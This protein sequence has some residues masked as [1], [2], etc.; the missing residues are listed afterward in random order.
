MEL[1]PNGNVTH[2]HSVV[3]PLDYRPYEPPNSR[4]CVVTTAVFNVISRLVGSTQLA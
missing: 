2:K 3:G 1:T 4:A